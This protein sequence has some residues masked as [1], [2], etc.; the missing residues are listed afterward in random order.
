MRHEMNRVV[1]GDAD[2]DR[3]HEQRVGIER[4]PEQ[5]HQPET[6]K[7]GNEIRHHGG[8]ATLQGTQGEDQHHADHRQ[9]DGKTLD[10]G[11]GN[12]IRHAPDQRHAAG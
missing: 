7:G 5:P 6:E 8:Q 12:L 2:D 4:N 1:H 11:D 3:R 10:L 9:G